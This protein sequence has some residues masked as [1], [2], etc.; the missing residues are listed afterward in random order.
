MRVVIGENAYITVVR[1]KIKI[2]L[3]GSLVFKQD[4]LVGYQAEQEAIQGMGF[5]VLECIGLYLIDRTLRLFEKV[6]IVLAKPRPLNRS[7]LLAI[8]LNDCHVSILT[9]K[10]TVVNIAVNPTKS[11]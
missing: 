11:T 4:V 5:M 1:T 9:G 10:S 8:N 3:D 7:N 6:Q 2:T